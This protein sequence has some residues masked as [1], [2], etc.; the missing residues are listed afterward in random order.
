LAEPAINPY[1]K[2]TPSQLVTALQHENQHW[3]TEIVEAHGEVT[4]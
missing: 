2:L 4:A 1:Q 3:V